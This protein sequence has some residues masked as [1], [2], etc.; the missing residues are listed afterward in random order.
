MMDFVSNWE[1]L[2]STEE[3]MDKVRRAHPDMSADEYSSK[4][5]AALELMRK[6]KEGS[7][8]SP[9]PGSPS[10][11]TKS[12][13]GT[14][15]DPPAPRSPLMKDLELP[16]STPP[17]KKRLVM[18]SDSEEPDDLSDRLPSAA[19]PSDDGSFAD[20]VSEDG[21][22][23]EGEQSEEQSEGDAETEG[24]EDAEEGAEDAAEGE[25]DDEME[26]EEDAEEGGEEDA[27]M[28]MA[29]E[30]VDAMAAELEETMEQESPT[31]TNATLK[32]IAAALDLEDDDAMTAAYEK[33]E[34]TEVKAMYL[35]D[36]ND[37]LYQKTQSFRVGLR[38]W[39]FIHGEGTVTKLYKGSCVVCFDDADQNMAGTQIGPVGYGHVKVLPSAPASPRSAPQKPKKPTMPPPPP[40]APT[41][42]PPAPPLI[43]LPKPTA[44]ELV[45]NK[46][47]V[48]KDKNDDS[49]DGSEYDLSK[50]V[51]GVLQTKQ[52]RKLGWRQRGQKRRHD[53]ALPVASDQ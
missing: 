17:S 46:K 8:D 43:V 52:G 18:M 12:P 37:P 16:P 9:A 28:Q 48:M 53:V 33:W 32:D 25:E 30:E 41:P 7:G 27:E 20:A 13:G 50:D 47:V 4:V 34:L 42:L 45:P 49:S 15:Y 23:E 51:L 24:E 29:A 3:Y 38:V 2:L 31:T 40:R 6:P 22:G 1:R 21:E 35:Q 11:V 5:F 19:D 36:E 39:H 44:P 26:G 10:G 14:C